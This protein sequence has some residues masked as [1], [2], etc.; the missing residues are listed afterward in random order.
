M[1][2]ASDFHEHSLDRIRK[3]LERA[4]EEGAFP[5]AVLLWGVASGKPAWLC[6]GFLRTDIPGERVT[7]NTLFDLASLTKPLVTASL[8]L[9]AAGEGALSLSRPIEELTP[10]PPGHYLRKQPLSRLLSH[11]SGLLPWAPLY[12]EI[13]PNNPR[14]FRKMLEERILDLPPD[15]LPGTQARYS[16]F[17]YILAGWIIER[18]Y[19]NRSLDR[20]FR[21]KVADPLA[22]RDTGFIE[23]EKSSPLR[24]HPI[25][26]TEMI[27]DLGVP[28][29]GLVHDEH[30]RYLGGVSGHAGLFAS[31]LSVWRLVLPW[32]GQG[33]LFHPTVL[34]DFL[35][36]QAGVSWTCG[37][38]TPT[39]NSQSGHRFSKNAI[40][41]LGYTGT[42]IWMEPGN[43]RIIILLTNRVHPSRTQNLLKLWRPR[44][45]DSVME[46]GFT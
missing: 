16:D 43:G 34:S 39:E 7:E 15:Y 8:A 3:I 14:L 11:T 23:I 41:H 32:M 30:A 29:T 22:V 12:R 19:G 24:M 33:N 18:I 2:D 25:A 38:D 1:T 45:Y 13:P 4:R 35:K 42:S 9:L 21:E 5:G 46:N 6:S 27:E 36:K 20:L 40:G 28:L 17:G 37:W 31:A 44:I 10:L 26:S